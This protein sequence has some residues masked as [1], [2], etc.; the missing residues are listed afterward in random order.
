MADCIFCR[1]AAGE[2]PARVVAEDDDVVAFEDVRP[3]AP[4]HVLVIPRRHVAGVHEVAEDGLLGR[5]VATAG[6]V[7]VERGVAEDGYRLVVNAGAD[8]GQEVLHLHLHLL[9]GRPMTWPPG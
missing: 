9:A 8:G 5:L 2:A 4:L 1:I 7:A 6:R 3:Q